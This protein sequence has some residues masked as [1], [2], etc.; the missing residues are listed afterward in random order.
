MDN[1]KS[2]YGKILFLILIFAIVFALSSS[3]FFNWPLS[4]YNLITGR[5]TTS[6]TSLNISV[7][8]TAPIITFVS[9][10]AATDPTE[11][12]TVNIRVNFTANDANGGSDLDRFG[13]QARFQFTGQTTR[14]NLSCSNVTGV[15][16]SNNMN[17]TCTVGMWYFD[18]PASWTANITINDSANARGENSTTT[19]TFNTLNAMVMSPT[20][21]T[22]ASLSITSTNVGSN[23]DPITINNTGNK[24]VT[25][26]TVTGI[27]LRGE[28]NGAFAIFARNISV[29]AVD[30]SDGFL[31]LN[32][33][34]VQVEN[35]T[36][37]RGNNSLNYGNETSGQEQIY[38]YVEA[39][40]PDLTSQA[41]STLAGGAWT[42]TSQ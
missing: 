2:V 8:N 32:N 15:F 18:V 33:S 25:N 29:N 24:N 23:N 28:S 13:G 6:T 7:T 39:L 4:L 21:L 42:V 14:S 11:S 37:L 31:M 38:F 27:D 16:S 26:V 36:L 41:Y 3:E 12:S 20:A 19:F 35:A 30:V 1:K 9:A 34:A 10:I 17:F 5:A 22:W 40:N